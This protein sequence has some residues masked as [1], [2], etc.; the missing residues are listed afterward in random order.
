MNAFET[1]EVEAGG[2]SAGL[3]TPGG[4]LRALARG[5][6]IR[7]ED[8]GVIEAGRHGVALVEIAT[9]RAMVLGTPRLLPSEEGGRP[10]LFVLRRPDDLPDEGRA[11]LLLTSDEGLAP[12]PGEAAL[13]L[14]DALG[15]FAED[16][17]FG[18]EGHG[19]LRVSVPLGAL[20]GAIPASLGIGGHRYRVENLAKKP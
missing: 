3:L 10:A 17:G 8:V 16:L 14:A 6:D 13:A 9:T 2:D 19:F 15:I 20:V 7:G 1:F 5:A 4:I 11:E 12:A 18:L